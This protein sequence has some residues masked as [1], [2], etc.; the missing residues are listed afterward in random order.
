MGVK[1]PSA[2]DLNVVALNPQRRAIGMQPLANPFGGIAK[3][4]GTVADYSANLAETRRKERVDFED[5][6]AKATVILGGDRFQAEID[7]LD[8]LDSMY[9]AKVRSS[10]R[11]HVVGPAVNGISDKQLRANWMQNLTEGEASAVTDA[12]ARTRKRLYDVNTQKLGDALNVVEKRSL[13]DPD[14]NIDSGREVALDMV[15]KS[16]LHPEDKDKL[17]RQIDEKYSI[18]AT[19]KA[20]VNATKT[21][22]MLAPDVAAA[23]KAVPG[24]PGVPDWMS[25]YLSRLASVESSGG[26]DLVNE[27]ST[28]RGPFQITEDTG[29]QYGLKSEADRMDV[30]KST[31]AAIRL[32][33]D[34]HAALKKGLGREP[35]PG[36]MYLAHQQGAAGALKLINN[37]DAKASDVVGEDAVTLNGG[38]EGMT[39]EQFASLWEDKFEQN[40]FPQDEEDA[41]RLL[42]RLPSFNRLSPEAQAETVKASIDYGKALEKQ[43]DD[44]AKEQRD[45][46]YSEFAELDASGQ[47][48][49]EWVDQQE[50]T[51]LPTAR[52]LRTFRLALSKSGT[53]DDKDLVGEIA[54]G[55]NTAKKLDDLD[56]V[57]RNL[58]EAFAEGRVSRETRTKLTAGIKARRMGLKDGADRLDRAEKLID[59]TVRSR[60]YSTGDTAEDELSSMAGKISLGNWLTAHPK[61]TELD[62]MRAAGEIARGVATDRVVTVRSSLPLPPGLEGR[63]VKSI[64]RADI[65]KVAATLADKDPIPG[66]EAEYAQQVDL[67]KRWLEVIDIAA[68]TF[69]NGIDGLEQ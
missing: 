39:S 48:T 45:Q 15:Q 40:S 46:I 33:I 51:G 18:G 31:E 8:P 57:E 37:P 47:L 29:K 19:N 41:T 1:L 25:G 3:A 6:N 60:D 54:A 38:F 12:R 21:G 34:N 68:P 28:A 11:K 2:A 59:R 63:D 56:E 22:I 36:E 7:K 35:T 13:G 66:R 23:I 55:V 62:V 50:A 10:Y 42:M 4:A 44:Q 52:E 16:S 20:V 67:V 61:A 14:G 5:S 9:E 49:K 58:T 53:S 24:I 17:L 27:A 43:R 32:S 26:T 65:A 30:Y 69:A 64:T